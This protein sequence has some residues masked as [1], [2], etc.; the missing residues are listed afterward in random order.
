MSEPIR[1]LIIIIT[2]RAEH[3][4]KKCSHMTMRLS[5]GTRMSH[6]HEQCYQR[7]QKQWSLCLWRLRWLGPRLGGHGRYGRSCLISCPK[8]SLYRR[9][10]QWLSTWRLLSKSRMS[11]LPVTKSR[12]KKGFV[13]LVSFSVFDSILRERNYN[14]VSY[15]V[16]ADEPR[17]WMLQIP[18]YKLL[19]HSTSCSHRNCRRAWWKLHT[20]NWICMRSQRAHNLLI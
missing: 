15:R 11:H 18:D 12:E 20:F 10:S 4:L 3:V 13:V 1:E 5:F 9:R 19:V 14:K 7:R 8:R 17:S 16:V 2:S 6:R